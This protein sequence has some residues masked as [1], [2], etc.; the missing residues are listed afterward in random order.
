MKRCYHC[1][2]IVWPWQNQYLGLATAH[3]ICDILKFCDDVAKH[4]ISTEQVSLRESHAYSKPI[5]GAHR[6]TIDGAHRWRKESRYKM[7]EESV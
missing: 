3:A 1:H 4:G 7:N 6:W 2:K 5:D